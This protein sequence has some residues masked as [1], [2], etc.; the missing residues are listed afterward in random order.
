MF[1]SKVCTRVGQ[2]WQVDSDLFIGNVVA[3]RKLSEENDSNKRDAL[4][5]LHTQHRDVDESVDQMVCD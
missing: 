5:E 1:N 2:Q 4:I 3:R